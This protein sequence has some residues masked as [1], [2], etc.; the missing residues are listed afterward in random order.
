[1]QFV[2]KKGI[3]SL[4]ILRGLTI[5]LMIIVNTPGSWEAIYT[6][7]EH[8][9]WHGFTITDLVFPT[10]LFVIGNAMSFSLKKY[11]A[12]GESAF[13]QK[14]VTRALIIFLIGLFLNGFPLSLVMLRRDGG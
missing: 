12:K 5:A 6:P 13:L 7:F 1:M 11:E 9:A 4:D 2:V 8:S 10:F 14:V 3:L